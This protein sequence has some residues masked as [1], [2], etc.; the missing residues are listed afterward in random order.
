MMGWDLMSSQGLE[1]REWLESIWEEGPES[2]E[3]R[4]HCTF[5]DWDQY[6]AEKTC[7]LK[8][9]PQVCLLCLMGELIQMLTP[10]NEIAKSLSK[11]DVMT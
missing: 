7:S 1:G 11:M 8:A 5:T 6:G 2:K 4:P 9:S 10:I 3:E